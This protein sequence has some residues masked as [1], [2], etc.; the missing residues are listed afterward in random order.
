MGQRKLK[1]AVSQPE[2]IPEMPE[3]RC[4]DGLARFVCLPKPNLARAARMLTVRG[5][6]FLHLLKPKEPTKSKEL[7]AC[8]PGEF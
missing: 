1:R 7:Q 5:F 2:M 8:K 4:L 3:R 6:Y